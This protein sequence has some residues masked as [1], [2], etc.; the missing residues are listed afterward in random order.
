MREVLSKL[1]FVTTALGASVAH[2]EVTVKQ[3]QEMGKAPEWFE[4]YLAGLGQGLSWAN[5]SLKTSGQN[6]I[7]CPPPKL[8]LTSANYIKIMDDEIKARESKP[9]LML[10]PMMLFGLRRTFPCPWDKYNLEFK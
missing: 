10:E 1:L 4:M 8:S 2:S 7:Y 9:D 3:Y 6:Q 5:V